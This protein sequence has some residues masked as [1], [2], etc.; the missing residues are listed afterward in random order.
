MRV[1]AQSA[2]RRGA[3]VGSGNYGSG[4]RAGVWE[5]SR[6]R[7]LSGVV[8]SEG[9]VSQRVSQRESE[10]TVGAPGVYR[11]AWEVTGRPRGEF[12]PD[13]SRSID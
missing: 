11:G 9:Q 2:R 1:G 12:V 7:F 8:V 13:S 10:E 3:G 4:K 5:A 6:G